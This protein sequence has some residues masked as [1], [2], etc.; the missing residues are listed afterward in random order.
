[1]LGGKEEGNQDTVWRRTM[2]EEGKGVKRL[3]GNHVCWRHFVDVVCSSWGQQEG[4]DCTLCVILSIFCTGP[5][6]CP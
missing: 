2:E 4:D 3:A 6:K 1:M 5:A